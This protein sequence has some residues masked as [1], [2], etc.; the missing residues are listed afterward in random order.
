MKSRTS[1]KKKTA[2]QVARPKP[3]R[4]TAPNRAAHRPSPKWLAYV[5]FSA[6]GLGALVIIVNFM[7]VL[8]GGESSWYLIGGIGLLAIG[9]WTAT[10]YR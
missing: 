4:Y 10:K 9:F 7:A 1:T 8:P 6:L 5:M 2:G 3:G